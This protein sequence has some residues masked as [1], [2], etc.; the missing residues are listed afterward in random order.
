MRKIIMICDRCG[1]KY[2]PWETKGK[3]LYGIAEID[4]S[5]FEPQLDMKMD[6]CEPCYLSLE[7]WWKDPDIIDEDKEKR[8]FAW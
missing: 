1:K 6:L 7:K 3:E 5:D 8:S 4:Y 2:D